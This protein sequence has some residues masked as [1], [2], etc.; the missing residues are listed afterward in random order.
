MVHFAELF[1]EEDVEMEDS[2]L[3]HD[4]DYEMYPEEHCQKVREYSPRGT[5]R[6]T[7]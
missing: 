6:R 4:L 5:G 2:G 3:I 7:T 1:N